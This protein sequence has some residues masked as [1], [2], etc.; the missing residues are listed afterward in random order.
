[1]RPAVLVLYASLSLSPLPAPEWSLRLFGGGGFWDGAWS[2]AAVGFAEDFG[3]TA[4]PAFL[5]VGAASLSAAWGSPLRAA[6]YASVGFGSWGGRFLFSGGS[7]AER[8]SSVSVGAAEAAFGLLRRFPLP[9]SYIEADARVACALAATAVAAEDEWADASATTT[10]TLAPED[11][12]FVYAGSSVGWGFPR[13]P[14]RFALLVGGDFGLA[15]FDGAG[16]DLALLYR[17]GLY[18]RLSY[19]PGGAGEARP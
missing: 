13:G 12:V 3:Q 7:A 10:S 16:A 17:A 15:A 19:A 14:F 4:A 8:R 9:S 2:A 11:A 5:P 1:M 6:P 18:F